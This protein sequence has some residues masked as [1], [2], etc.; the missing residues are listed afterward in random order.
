VRIYKTYGAEAV[1]VVRKN[2]YRLARDI[3]GI[4]FRT[5]DT[6][7]ARLGIERTAMVRVRAGVSFA[8]GEAMED[9]HCGLPEGELT[10]LV[11]SLLEV[12]EA[13]VHAALALELEAGDV[14]ADTLDGARCIFLA[15]L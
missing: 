4:G 3:R 7:A 2:P 8:L 6:I 10:A 1:R 15:G 13:L 5:A 11:G 12:E 14:V 9:G